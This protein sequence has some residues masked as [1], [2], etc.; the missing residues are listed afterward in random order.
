[1]C[2]PML[3][4]RSNAI[5]KPSSVTNTACSTYFWQALYEYQVYVKTK[6]NT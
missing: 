4:K 1:M 5:G 3:L 6:D 2:N